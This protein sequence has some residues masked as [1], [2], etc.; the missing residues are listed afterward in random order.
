ML[1]R[2]RNSFAYRIPV[3]YKHLLQVKFRIKKQ[4][5]FY[6]ESEIY[7]LLIF[8]GVAQL[9]MLNVCLNSIYR[10]F[11]KRPHIYIVTDE[12][13]TEKRCQKHTKWFPA[14]NLTIIPGSDCIKHHQKKGNCRLAEFAQKNTMGLKMAAIL[15]VMDLGRPVLYCDTDV[16]WYKDPL[17]N[18]EGLLKDSNFSLAL[19]VDFQ[20]SYDN[21]LVKLKN[22][23]ELKNSPFFCAGIIFL[24]K[25]SELHNQLLNDLIPLQSHTP[26]HF[27]EQTI[28]ASINKRSGD[29]SLD[30]KKYI[31]KLSDKLDF[32]PKNSNGCLARHYVG[33]V[34]HL[35]WRD[36]IFSV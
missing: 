28:F 31:I 15:Y 22:L 27:T 16:I 17:S 10:N 18:L 4:L 6:Q 8:S 26:N 19:S 35:F 30:P 13:L 34:R 5:K 24:K 7:N 36:A 1:G 29:I 20:S 25:F 21:S 32:I 9:E 12:I 23:F 3:V 14:K 33:E 11:D 2:I